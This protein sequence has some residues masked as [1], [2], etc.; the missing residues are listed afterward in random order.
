MH[1]YA[2]QDIFVAQMPQYG[3]RWVAK[4]FAELPL[5]PADWKRTICYSWYEFDGMFFFQQMDVPG[6]HDMIQV[7]RRKSG[8]AQLH[9]IVFN[10][11]TTARNR[12]TIRYGALA[13]I[14]GDLRPVEF[15]RQYAQ[16]MGISPLETYVEVAYKIDQA[17]ER[18]RDT[19]NIGFGWGWMWTG[20]WSTTLAGWKDEVHRDVQRRFEEILAD[21]KRLSAETEDG[22]WYLDF[23]RNRV[24]CS[25][26][27]Y[28]AVRRLSRVLPIIT[29][30]DRQ[31]ADP[32]ALTDEERQQVREA[33]REATY[34]SNQYMS[35]LAQQ[36][37]E[38]G[39]EGA[40]LNYYY[41]LPQTLLKLRREYGGDQDAEPV[42]THQSDAW[43][44][45]A[46]WDE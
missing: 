22:R 42:P 26:Y 37:P 44:A 6:V 36:M 32:A 9:A 40:L 31:P 12:T 19:W 13:T 11:W 29:Q 16:R 23:L 10:V 33:C 15:L 18:A 8:S 39:S 3:S 21:L 1:L 30:P 45:P 35:T 28:R 46:R 24:E 7:A 25:I 4:R 41:C 5:T 27:H 17:V 14:D 38:R 43:P 2:P 20:W 34:W